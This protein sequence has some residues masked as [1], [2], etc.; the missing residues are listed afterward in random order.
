V[1][2]RFLDNGEIARFSGCWF[3]F[4]IHT[5]T[6]QRISSPLPITPEQL[7]FVPLFAIRRIIS[8][9]Q[10]DQGGDSRKHRWFHERPT[11]KYITLTPRLSLKTMTLDILTGKAYFIERVCILK[12]ERSQITIQ[13]SPSIT[14]EKRKPL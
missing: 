12:P 5:P 13:L 7:P 3:A 9:P 4:I 8:P 14:I 10:F 2:V 6:L 11:L 1:Y